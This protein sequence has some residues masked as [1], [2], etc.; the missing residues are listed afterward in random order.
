MEMRPFT[1]WFGAL[2]AVCVLVCAGSA[3]AGGAPIVIGG[4]MS[5]T[6]PLTVDAQY[7]LRGTE[8]AVDEINQHGGWLGR[9]VEL[10]I[11]DDESN[12]GTAVRLYTRLITEDRVDLLIGPYSSGITQ[13]IAPLVNKYHMATLEPGAS[14]PDIFVKGN[15]WNIQAIS[16]SL[17]YLQQ[18]LPIAKTDGARTVALL[19][20]KSA[21]SLACYRAREDQAKQLGLKIV[22]TATYSLPTPD[23]AGMALAIKNARPDVVIGCTY[24]PDSVG[25]TKALHDQGFAPRFL[26]L[27]IGPVEASFEKAVGSLANGIISNTSWWYNY[28]TP[29]NQQFIDAYKAKYNQMPDY[30]AASGYAAINVLGAAVKAIHSLNQAKLRDWLLH[31]QVET[32]EGT[33]KVNE[34]GLCTGFQQQIVQVQNG[35]LKLITPP[36]LAQAKLEVPYPGA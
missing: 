34:Y 22:Y 20:L 2:A 23:F 26:A 1:S 13:A 18:L 4:T 24:Y 16:S 19:A 25:L 17:Q 15:K 28:K 5:E 36:D 31:H 30:H 29:G 35:E 33:F 21:Y 11:Y 27:T 3:L 14:L 12:P 7:Q 32:V 10:K 8:L 9:K 6:G